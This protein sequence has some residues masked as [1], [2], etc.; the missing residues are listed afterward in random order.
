MDFCCKNV[1]FLQHITTPVLSPAPKLYIELPSD[2]ESSRRPSTASGK[3]A[4]VQCTPCG[5]Y[6]VLF[7]SR[8]FNGTVVKKTL[9]L[10]NRECSTHSELHKLLQTLLCT[11]PLHTCNRRSL[12]L[13]V[14][15]LSYSCYGNIGSAL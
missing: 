9:P 8:E 12:R 6:H 5:L 14:L 7:N 13:T 4:V 10:F 11:R 3:D 15:A 1:H 2:S